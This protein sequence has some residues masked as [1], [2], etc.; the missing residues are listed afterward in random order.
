M[1]Q[2]TQLLSQPQAQVSIP[3]L[4]LDIILA[5]VCA[6]MLAKFYD[7]YGY[8]LSNRSRL[9]RNF[10]PIAVTTALII[11]IVKS[12]LALSLGLVG[13]LSIVRFRS[14]I[15]EPEE[16]AF[17]F[18]AIAVGLGFGANQHIVTLVAFGMI[19]TILYFQRLKKELTNT[20]LYLS[21]LVPGKKQVDLGPLLKVLKG[22]CQKLDIRRVDYTVN[23]LEAGFYVEYRDV[24]EL[25]QSLK[26][27]KKKYPKAELN[28]IDQSG[29]LV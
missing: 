16:L 27:L 8:S 25:Q 21:V 28:L 20:N 23:G 9:S 13:A 14:A 7:R 6:A 22:S 12:S 2:L 3:V 11:T 18:L 24:G 10:I 26:T 5:A 17:L 19:L 4:I 1:D 15:K 29:M